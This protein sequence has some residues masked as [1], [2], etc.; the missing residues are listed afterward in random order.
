MTAVFDAEGIVFGA[1]II[2]GND[3]QAGL[4]HRIEDG[5]GYVGSSR[6]LGRLGQS[7]GLQI[8]V[9]KSD[10]RIA[11]LVTPSENG[12]RAAPGFPEPTSKQRALKR[13]C[14]AFHAGMNARL[15]VNVL[16]PPEA[17]ARQSIVRSC[18]TPS[19]VWIRP[20]RVRRNRRNASA[21]GATRRVL[22][23]C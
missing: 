7:F 5:R 20:G 16:R 4:C 11:R 1:R 17:K 23:S 14:G 12:H 22:R 21:T 6:I 18:W 3:Q 2:R 13:L 8:L 10:S 15:F 19:T 9:V